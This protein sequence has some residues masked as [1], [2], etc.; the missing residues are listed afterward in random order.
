MREA[1]DVRIT[2]IIHKAAQKLQTYKTLFALNQKEFQLCSALVNA[3]VEFV[4]DFL[5]DH[6]RTKKMPRIFI[7]QGARYWLE[8][9]T[10]G[11]VYVRVKGSKARFSSGP[12]SI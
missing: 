5:A 3:A 11:R 7:W 8:Y 10:L 2:Q 12:L 4:N 1:K 6:P 9:S